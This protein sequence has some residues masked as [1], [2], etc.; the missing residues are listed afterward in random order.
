MAASGAFAEAYSTVENVEQLVESRVQAATAT[1]TQLQSTAL[2][3]VSAL[4]NVNLNFN[5][6]NP[7]ALPNIDPSI[8]VNLNLPNISPTSFGTITSNVPN[9]PAL[10]PVPA[11]PDLTIPDFVSSI[12]SLN[13]P[14]APAWTAPPQV[15]TEPTIDDVVVPDMPALVIPAAPALEE[16]TVLAGE[17][18]QALHAGEDTADCLIRLQA[19]LDTAMQRHTGRRTTL[20]IAHSLAT[21]QNAD[22]IIVLEQGRIVEQGTHTALLAQGGVYARLAALQFT[23]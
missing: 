8:N 5:A 16:I 12:D 17:A 15:P 13:I 23:A 22:R 7:P 10:D 6:G 1:A 20:V 9:T 4:G 18:A 21:V 19:A 11:I 14:N 2:Q 3:T